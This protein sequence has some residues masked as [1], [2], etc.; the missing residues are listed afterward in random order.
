MRFLIKKRK[1]PP[2]T[3]V[4]RMKEPNVN[5]KSWMTFSRV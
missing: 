5:G 1:R 3:V 4:M 2:N